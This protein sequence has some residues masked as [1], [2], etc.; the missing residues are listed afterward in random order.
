MLLKFYLYYQ[1]YSHTDSVFIFL[2]LWTL[3]SKD[4]ST[5]CDIPESKSLIRIVVEV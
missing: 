5:L 2:S 4:G 3:G 1:Y